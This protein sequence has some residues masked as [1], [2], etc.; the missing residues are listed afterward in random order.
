MIA[1]VLIA[2]GGLVAP[3]FAK[4]D[5]LYLG[6]D[7]S[8]QSITGV[9]LDNQ[10]HPVRPAASVNFDDSF[11]EY[12]TKAGM[13]VGQDGVVTSPVSMWLRA[14]DALFDE[15]KGT[16][17]LSRVAAVSC[18]GQQ[19]GSVYWTKA[20]LEALSSP[21]TS[22][23]SFAEA[24]VGAFA[25]TDSPIWADSST[26]PE[27]DAIEA[28]FSG[29]AGS[30]S[31]A[32]AVARLTGSRAYA[33]FTG[34]QI[35]AVSRRQPA[36]WAATERVSLVSSWG[37]AL[38]TGH[39]VPMDTSDAS[40]TLLMDIETRA[41]A[42]SMLACDVMPPDLEQ[43]LG[44]PPV[45]G[46]EFV[47]TVSPFAAQAS[48]LPE[49]C[50]VAASSGDNPCAIAGLGLARAGDLALS[51]GTSDTLLG[52]AA[53]AAATPATEGH[54][55]VHPA[56]PASVFGMLCYKN[57]GA[58]RKAVRDEL[59]AADWGRFDE[60]LGRTPPANG[61]VLGL[62][63]PLPEITP[64]ID[65]S[66]EWYVDS[67]GAIVPKN[68]LSASQLVRAVVE[69][70]F[71]SMRARGGAIGLSSAGGRVLATG[72]GSQSAGILQVAADVFGAPVLASDTPDAA[73]IGAARR[74]AYA[75]ALARAQKEPQDLS[76]ADFLKQST[77]EK[78]EELRVVAKPRPEA[79]AAYDDA[80]V[81]RYKQLEDMVAA[82]GD[83]D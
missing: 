65:R 79:M 69:G 73:A 6:L 4:P 60:A 50:M 22:A 56:D 57:G 63:L 55:M 36:A 9:L 23:T 18:S 33:R 39:H 38:L 3:P 30:A 13:S 2:T 16:G 70:R 54:I 67:T 7:L 8:T 26:Q 78:A 44:G 48:G 32:A 51:L 31:G 17:L 12:G 20:G 14:L 35:A 72:G 47:G 59:C 43:R 27:C 61:G 46:H 71:L 80:L 1:I 77:L 19:H 15:L 41:W 53:A 25:V 34:P 45:P 24:L 81:A 37:A 74:A 49:G 28:A 11:P 75:L 10:L 5:S 83:D 52:V 42:P 64:I 76:Y 62:S 21:P 82:G 40:G 29:S 66:G 68:S 58:A